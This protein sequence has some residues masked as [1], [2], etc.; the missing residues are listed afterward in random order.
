MLKKKN[1]KNRQP[2]NQCGWC[3]FFCDSGLYSRLYTS[4]TKLAQTNLDYPGLEYNLVDEGL[5]RPRPALGLLGAV[6]GQHVGGEG[7]HQLFAEAFLQLQR[8][9]LPAQKQRHVGLRLCS[10]KPSHS[11]TPACTQSLRTHIQ[12]A[13]L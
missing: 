2:Q 9:R 7:R 3:L 6:S 13:W 5:P 8:A 12:R 1:L 4:E 10:V 11:T